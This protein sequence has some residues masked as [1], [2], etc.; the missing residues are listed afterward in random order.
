MQVA[1]LKMTFEGE[2]SQ[3][4]RDLHVQKEYILTEHERNME[5]LK[6][7]HQAE[8][9]GLEARLK[10]RQDK[11]EKVT[12]YLLIIEKKFFVAGCKHILSAVNCNYTVFISLW[13]HH[14]PLC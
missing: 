2:K 11:Y 6:E 9:Q 1:E 8:L 3:M 7:L 5:N 12:Y 13:P 4:L 14:T 10:E